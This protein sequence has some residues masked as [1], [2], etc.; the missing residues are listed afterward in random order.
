ML[1][2]MLIY[3]I[4][5]SIFVKLYAKLDWLTTVKLGV[6]VYV[7]WLLLAIMLCI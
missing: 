1:V 5:A 7:S 2:Q 6:G 3:T 4:I